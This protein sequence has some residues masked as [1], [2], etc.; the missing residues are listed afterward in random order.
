MTSEVARRGR[1]VEVFAE[2]FGALAVASPDAFRIKFRKMAASPVSF[3]RG[4]AALFYA[5]L[6]AL[7]DP[8]LDARTSRVWIH[9]DLHAENFGTYMNDAGVIVFDVNDFDEAYVGPFMWDLRRLAAGLA[10][11]GWEKALS[12]SEIEQLVATAA[13][14]YA[15]QVARFVERGHDHRFALTREN[16]RGAVHA[17]LLEASTRTRA[18]M[19][20]GVTAIERHDR[21]FVE[22]TNVLPLPDDERELVLEGFERYLET[23][24]PSKRDGLPRPRVKDVVGRRGVGIGSAGLRSYNLLV[25]GATQALETDVL[26][27]MKQSQ[28]AAPSRF[29]PDADV[30]DYFLHEGHRTVVSQRA[31]QVHADPWLGYTTFEDAGQLVAEVSPYAL[32]LDWSNVNSTDAILELVGYLGRATAKIHCVADEASD[33]TLVNFHTEDAID[34]VLRNREAELAR[35]LVEFAHAYAARVRDDHRLFVDAFRNGDLAFH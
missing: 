18:E 25:E 30:R 5:D 24:P 28:P 21:R 20:A 6:A 14:A 34:A 13:G 11:V 29:V 15:A 4:S 27:Y 33:Q 10:L 35:E 1:I 3:Y 9:G 2:C 32:D 23:V 12:D 31:L 7:D 26:L 22:D 19:L 8:F 17:L 16:T